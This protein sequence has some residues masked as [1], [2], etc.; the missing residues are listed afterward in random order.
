MMNLME[1]KILIVGAGPTGLMAALTLAGQGIPFRIIYKHSAPVTTSNALAIQSLTMELWEKMGLIEEAL[2][3]GYPVKGLTISRLKGELGRISLEGLP[4]KYPFI[5][6]LPQAKTENMLI[7]RLAKL[8]VTVERNVCLQS[9][10]EYED[11][12][13]VVCSDEIAEY[14]WVIGCDGANST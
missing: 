5:L 3:L 8:G 7:Q 11:R 2:K 4:T 1:A 12:I 6:I 9:L 14:E 10:T 13:E